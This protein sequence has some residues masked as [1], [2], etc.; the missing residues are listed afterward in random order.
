MTQHRWSFARAALVAA[1]FLPA[2]DK[3]D[4]EDSG[5]NPIAKPGDPDAKAVAD[6]VAAT[7]PAANLPKAEEILA[8]AVEAVGGEDKLSKVE[9]FYYKGQVSIMG[10][11][12]GGPIEIWWKN[13]DF[14]TTQEMMGVGTIKAGKSGATIWSQD[15]INGLRKLE[16]AEGEQHLWASSL[17]LAADWKN[18][19]A[20]AKTV[21]ERED[22]AKTLYD[23][24][25]TSKSG[26]K[27]TMSFDKETGLQ[28]GQSFQQVT[29]MGPMPIS[30]KMD[31]YRTV[32]PH[33]IRI[34][35][36][37]M[38]DA[39]LMKATQEI[40][41]LTVNAEVDT[42]RFA[43]PTAGAEVVSADDMGKK[44]GAMMPFDEDGKP[45]KPVPTKQK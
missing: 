1:L 31:D 3:E 32:E 21:A 41:E 37:Q 44:K 30:V 10:Q 29:P 22:G 11:N 42:T 39:K 7:D 4:A 36:R 2:C 8:K 14:F 19:F 15:P 45:G 43:M 9:S 33:G 18:Y 27:I 12:M 13:G 23:V 25:L 35:F 26:A 20:E 5:S 38:T 34:A 40:S 28:S 24:E 16:G 6:A 17:M